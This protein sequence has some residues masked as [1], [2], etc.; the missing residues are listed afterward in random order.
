MY[1]LRL[2]ASPTRHF[3]P[4][5]GAPPAGCSGTRADPQ[6]SPGH[7]CVFEGANNNNLDIVVI[8]EA[9]PGEGRYG[10]DFEV[11]AAGAGNYWDYGTYAVTAPAAT[12]PAVAPERVGPAVAGTASAR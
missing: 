10:F 9:N 11:F 1:N 3:I 5:G 2:P 12:G 6:A 8:F 7:L 4:D